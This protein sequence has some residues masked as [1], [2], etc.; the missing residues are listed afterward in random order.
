MRVEPAK[1]TRTRETREA[2]KAR[3]DAHSAGLEGANLAGGKV[4]G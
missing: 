4:D 3:V 2:R 1:P